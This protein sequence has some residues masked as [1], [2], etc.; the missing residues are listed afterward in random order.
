MKPTSVQAG[1]Y[2]SWVATTDTK[3]TGSPIKSDSLPPARA[4]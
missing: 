2:G 4:F 3:L 1:E